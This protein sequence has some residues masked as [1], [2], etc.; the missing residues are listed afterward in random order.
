MMSGYV[1]DPETRA[2]APPDAVF[3]AKPFRQSELAETIARALGAGQ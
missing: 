2:G 3:L 1:R